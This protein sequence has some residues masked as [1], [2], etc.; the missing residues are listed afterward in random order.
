MESGEAVSEKT[1]KNNTILY[2]YLADGQRQ[3][4]PGDKILIATKKF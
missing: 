1:F 2:M 3:L 4:P